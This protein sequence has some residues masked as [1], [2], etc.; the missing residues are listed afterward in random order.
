MA[1]DITSDIQNAEFRQKTLLLAIA[2]RIDVIITM[3][4]ASCQSDFI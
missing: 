4:A 3:N 1:E 2:M